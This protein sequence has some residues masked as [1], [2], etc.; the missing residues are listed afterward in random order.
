MY[1]QL[2]PWEEGGISLYAGYRRESYG[3][4]LPFDISDT[5]IGMISS[6]LD[7]MI[8]DFYQADSCSL[9][10]KCT[11]PPMAWSRPRAMG[12]PSP[13]PPTYRRLPESA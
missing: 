4:N 3:V 12:I 7:Q 11:K 8:D 9:L 13:S 2:F 6:E 5:G 10:S 1:F